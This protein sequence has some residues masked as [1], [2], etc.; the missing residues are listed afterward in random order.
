MGAVQGPVALVSTA[1]VQ[2]EEPLP[3]AVCTVC[4]L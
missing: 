4:G 2:W 3:P 1:D